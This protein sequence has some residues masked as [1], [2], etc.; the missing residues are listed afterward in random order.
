MQEEAGN[1]IFL[2][3][4]TILLCY[5]PVEH[6]SVIVKIIKKDCILEWDS[7][8]L[9]ATPFTASDCG[10]GLPCKFQSIVFPYTAPTQ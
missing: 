1:L 3:D 7:F 9:A 4:F 5:I 8:V 2:L 10:G 6:F